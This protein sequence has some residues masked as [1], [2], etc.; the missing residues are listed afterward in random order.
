MVHFVHMRFLDRPKLIALGVFFLGVFVAVLFL[1]FPQTQRFYTGVQNDGYLG[2]LVAGVMYAISFAAPSAT[3]I[4]VHLGQ[5]LNM[6]LAAMVGG[7]GA[8]L[9]DLLIF[10]VARRGSHN[11]FVEMIKNKLPGRQRTP[12]WVLAL[13]GMVIL[14]SPLPDELAAGM[15]GLSSFSAKKFLVL[16]FALNTLG[17]FILLLFR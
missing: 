8:L 10:T 11:R 16:S 1:R 17:I 15:L 6:F 13:F 9:Y 14:A 5:H 12:Q 3:I 4:F 7:V 2:A